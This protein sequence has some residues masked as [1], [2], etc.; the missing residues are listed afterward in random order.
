M[1][2]ASRSRSA[3]SAGLRRVAACDDELGLA[4]AVSWRAPYMTSGPLRKLANTGR[5]DFVDMHLSHVSQMIMEGFLGR[6]DFAIIE[7]TDITARRPGLPDHRDR[8]LRPRSCR[9][10]SR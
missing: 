4:E 6:V 8:Q 1:R 9:R 10:P 7:A 5:L 2:R 3:S